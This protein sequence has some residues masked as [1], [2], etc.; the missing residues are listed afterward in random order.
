MSQKGKSKN[1]VVD[2]FK[3]CPRCEKNKTVGEYH[4][5]PKK[6]SSYC[7]DCHSLVTRANYLKTKSLQKSQA[8]MRLCGITLEQRDALFAAQGCKCDICGIFGVSVTWHTDHDHRT[9]NFR[10]VLCSFCNNMLGMARDNPEILRRGVLY[11]TVPS[12]VEIT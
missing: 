12:V 4:F 7:K 6:M 10:G 11:L 5:T 2:G 8:L 1:F 3:V 9:D